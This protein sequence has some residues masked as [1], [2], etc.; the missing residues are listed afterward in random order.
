[1]P[2]QASG[3]EVLLGEKDFIINKK[4]NSEKK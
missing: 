2:F 1:V 3:I 4:E